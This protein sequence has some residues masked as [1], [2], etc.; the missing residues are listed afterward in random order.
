MA[1]VIYLHILIL[2]QIYTFKFEAIATYKLVSEVNS[3]SVDQKAVKAPQELELRE[4]ES[5]PCEFPD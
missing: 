3:L 2:T 5:I 1:Y 4:F